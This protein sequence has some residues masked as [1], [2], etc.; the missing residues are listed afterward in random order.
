MSEYVKIA[1]GVKMESTVE[2]FVEHQNVQ[3]VKGDLLFYR[4]W[5]ASVILE[6]SRKASYAFLE[7][8]NVHVVLDLLPNISKEALQSLFQK[9]LACAKGKSLSLWLEGMIPKKLALFILHRESFYIKDASELGAKEIKKIV[10]A[11]K[12]QRLNLHKDQRF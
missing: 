7:E 10:F 9:R 5:F 6:I 12:A 4:L 8:K 1:S 2:L 11:L 3:R